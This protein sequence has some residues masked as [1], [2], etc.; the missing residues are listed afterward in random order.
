MNPN[1]TVGQVTGL[2]TENTFTL[3]HFDGPIINTY[4]YNPFKDKGDTTQ[5]Y[6]LKTT[7]SVNNWEPPTDPEES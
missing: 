5:M 6:L 3:S 1:T 2:T 4:R 7:E